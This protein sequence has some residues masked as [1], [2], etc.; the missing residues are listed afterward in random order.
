MLIDEVALP[1]QPAIVNYPIEAVLDE[2]ADQVLRL[3][4]LRAI[5]ELTDFSS[6]SPVAGSDGSGTVALPEGFIKL[7]Q[8]KMSAWSSDCP[9]VI[10]RLDSRYQL[11]SNSYTRGNSAR[12]VVVL[13]SGE[14]CY[15]S[16]AS[17]QEHTIE[18]AKA[19]CSIEAGESY[20]SGLIDPLCWL[21]A[22]KTLLIM[23]E[24]Q[25]AAYAQ[26][27]AEELILKL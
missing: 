8:F 2:A 27:Q 19:V 4:P 11:Q 1:T 12:P 3:A 7:A 14:L 25:E 17:D 6:T 5:T 26:K 20:P 22:S 13:D 9:L 21:A 24:E 18:S 15:Y 10:D 23:R 16:V